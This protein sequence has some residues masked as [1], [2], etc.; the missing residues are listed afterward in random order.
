[1]QIAAM[2]SRKYE[3][4]FNIRKIMSQNFIH[5]VQSHLDC[6]EELTGTNVTQ[7]TPGNDTF[8]DISCTA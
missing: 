5:N 6:Q 3:N 4:R 1:M 2:E 8:L 7:A